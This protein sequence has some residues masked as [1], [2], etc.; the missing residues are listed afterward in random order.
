MDQYSAF[1]ALLPLI[2]AEL[3]KKGEDV[4]R[5]RY[6]A[7]GSS[8]DADKGDREEVEDRSR[9]T[10]STSNGISKKSNIEATSDEDEGE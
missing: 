3:R 9:E 4:P 10:E 5:P 6:D 2:E 8:D 1:I 7:S